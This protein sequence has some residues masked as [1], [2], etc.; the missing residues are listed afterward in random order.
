MMQNSSSRGDA[1]S[2]A[3]AILALTL[4]GGCY[5]GLSGDRDGSQADDDP[6]APAEGNRVAG[7]PEP[8]GLVARS[9]LRRLTVDEYDNT[10]RDL[11]GDASRP[12]STLLPADPY[13]PFDNDYTFQEPSGALVEGLERLAMSAAER[14]LDDPARRDA[15]VG[16]IPASLHDIDCFREFVTRFGRL[17]FRRPLEPSEIE[18]YVALHAFGVERGD[19]HAGVGAVV[20]AMLQDPKFMYRVEVGN[21]VPGV[22]GTFRLND[23]EIAT[24]LSYFLWGS[25]PDEALL[26]TAEAGG[27]STAAGIR[28]IAR[29]MLEDPRAIDRID[30]FHA[31]WLGYE[32]MPFG[33]T[34]ADAMRVETKALIERVVF[35]ERQPWEAIFTAEETFVADSLAQ[36]YGLPLPG[37]ADPVWTSYGDSGRRGVLSHGTFL[38]NGG[39]FGDTSP[40]QR[41]LV[42]RRNLLCQTLPEPPPGVDPDDAP[43][44]DEGAACKWDRYAAHREDPGCVAC[45]AMVDPIGF[46]LENYDELGRFRTHDE[47]APDCP[48]SGD[49]AIIEFG[50]FN[51]PEQLAELVTTSAF[52]IVT[53]CMIEQLYRFLIGRSDLAADDHAFLQDFSSRYTDEVFYFDDLLLEI[54]SSDVFRFRREDQEG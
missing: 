32:A 42:I 37:S 49:G 54:V 13:I 27:L 20:Q 16:C 19:F 39:K 53:S 8:P 46:G 6:P 5:M 30:R 15:V 50:D 44:L 25:A 1:R 4:G 51:G 18:R 21:P 12:G 24:R 43:G 28:P 34:I 48:I 33:G 10:L 36:H 23:Y 2:A 3:A 45:H 11:L 7:D 47:G 41:G 26:D 52:H 17:A 14:L 22:P 29:Q 9:G 38:S 40:T 35:A 31:L